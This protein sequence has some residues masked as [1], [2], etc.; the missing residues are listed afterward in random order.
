MPDYS[1]G[2]IYTIRCKTDTSL[3]YVGS[4]IQSL[5]KRFAGHKLDKDRGYNSLLYKQINDWNDWFI[6]L[7][8]NCPCNSVEELR[9]KEGEIIRLIGTLNY[10]IAG[11]NHKEYN[12]D[13]KEKYH[14]YR[15]INAEKMRNYA[16][17]YR[18]KNYEKIK[19]E[20][21]K[22]CLCEC[23]KQYTQ[24]HKIRHEKTKFHLDFLKSI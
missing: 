1:K 7:Y 9:K 24:G 12:D 21:S 3:I 11:R 4:T 20:K 22:I 6:E 14:E 8:E 18:A 15:K 19:E 16:K 13:N 17:E 23:G 10:Q 2:K 5:S